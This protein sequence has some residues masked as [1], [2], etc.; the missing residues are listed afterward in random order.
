MNN[1]SESMNKAISSNSDKIDGFKANI[2][3]LKDA[4]ESTTAEVKNID[5]NL[6]SFEKAD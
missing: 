6:F 1:K 5:T 3:N 2:Q 4:I